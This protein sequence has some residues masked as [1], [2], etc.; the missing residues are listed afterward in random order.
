[1]GPGLRSPALIHWSSSGWCCC[2]SI[3]PIQYLPNVMLGAVIVVAALGLVN[4]DDC[5][6]LAG[7]SRLEVT[8][9]R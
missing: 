3:G 8:R 2:C 5:E 4:F 6:V 7:I 9:S 1:M